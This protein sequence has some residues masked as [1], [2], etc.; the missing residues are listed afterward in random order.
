LDE[1]QIPS[2]PDYG[3]KALMYVFDYSLSNSLSVS[4]QPDEYISIFSLRGWG[5]LKGDVLT[6]E[7]V[8][9]VWYDAIVLIHGIFHHRYTFTA[10][11][12]QSGHVPIYISFHL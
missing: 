3:R 2:F 10:R 1:V 8:R 12:V 5:K 6:T 11:C 4:T 9:G 7:Q